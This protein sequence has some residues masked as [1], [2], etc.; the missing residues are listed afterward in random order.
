MFS[1]R[2][3]YT[4]LYVGS[5]VLTAV[6]MNV[7]IFWDIAPCTRTGVSEERIVFT[8]RVENQ[9]SHPLNAV[10]LVG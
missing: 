6:V 8:F 3:A 10:L 7:A 9:P 5:E 2:L 1:F 4:T